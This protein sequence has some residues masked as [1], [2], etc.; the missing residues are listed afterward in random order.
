MRRLL[1]G[2]VAAAALLVGCADEEPE[3]GTDRDDVPATLLQREDL[4]E[5]EK[6]TTDDRSVLTRT[7]CAAME[8]EYNLTITDSDDVS[9]LYVLADG[10]QVR[11]SLQ[12][13]AQNQTT[14]DPTIDQ[15]D[16][17]ITEC[18]T[19]EIPNGSFER[20]EGL[21][22]GA[23]GFRT[24]QD[25]SEG[26]QTTE[27]V[28]APADDDT[29]VVVTVDHVGEGEPSVSAAELLPQAVQRAQG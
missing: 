9:A 13:P 19:A 17:A 1:I 28:Y 2:A 25:T 15:V 21:P 10:D 6:V 12:G 4:P 24:V 3:G 16:A 5:V 20:I 26:P 18:L 29:A 23:I 22:D 11:S 8:G 27:R 14:I 7:N